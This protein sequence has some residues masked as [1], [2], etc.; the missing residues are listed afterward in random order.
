[1]S[2]PDPAPRPPGVHSAW[3]SATVGLLAGVAGFAVLRRVPQPPP[4]VAGPPRQVDPGPVPVPAGLADPPWPAFDCDG[5][6]LADALAAWG[7]RAGYAVDVDW[8]S[9]DNPRVSGDLPVTVRL[10]DTTAAGALDAILAACPP[11]GD[12]GPPAWVVPAGRGR[13]VV[14][15]SRSGL[16]A[17]DQVTRVYDVGPIVRSMLAG[18]AAAGP[19][20]A[21][22]VAAEGGPCLVPGVRPDLSESDA[23]DN[24]VK[25]VTE[26]VA[27][28]VWRVNGGDGDCSYFNGSLVVRTSTHV[29]ADVERFLAAL[30]G[31]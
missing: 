8:K 6:P 12:D 24:L 22:P 26:H 30:H 2:P 23:G 4:D 3:R 25:A 20:T 18:T 15:T 14:V 19:A 16:D 7:R 5:Q 31:R 9:V 28:S 27:P 11:G 21:G 13:V 10:R 17:L 1:M 29:Q